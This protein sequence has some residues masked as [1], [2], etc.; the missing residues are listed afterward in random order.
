MGVSPIPFT[1]I[2]DYFKV[3]PIGDDFEEFLYLIR[4]MDDALIACEQSKTKG[5]VSSGQTNGSQKNSNKGGHPG[6]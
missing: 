4:A 2:L 1:A 6:R 3:Y 5:V